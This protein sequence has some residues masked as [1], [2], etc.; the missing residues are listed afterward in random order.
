M[1]FT[2]VKANLEKSGYKVSCFESAKEAAEY[3]DSSIDGMSVGFGGS[4][5]LEE[6][7]IY[8]MLKSHNEV[9]WHWKESGV[10]TKAQ[11]SDVYISSVN[12]I[13]ES[14]EIINIDGNCNRVAGI[15]YGH[16]K[17]YLVAGANKIVQD[18][19]AA[20][21]RA[22]NVV[23]PLNAKRLGRNTPCAVKTDKCYDCNSPERICKGLSVLWQKPSSCEY[24][25]VLIAENL[26][27]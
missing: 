25:V 22:R 13:A 11:T 7:G 15:L 6:M 5:T 1:D 19:D 23:A 16:K 21:F 14:G 8:E 24:E 3:M 10:L 12:A 17:V 18:Y 9:L 2:T 26:G 27:Y 20:V 4:M